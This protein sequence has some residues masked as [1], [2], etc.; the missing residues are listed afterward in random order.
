MKT[1]VLFVT[2][3]LISFT[4]FGCTTQTPDSN[5]STNI[6]SN[7]NLQVPSN[8]CDS[9]DT[10]NSRDECWMDIVRTTLDDSLCNKITNMKDDCYDVLAFGKD[11]YQ[12]CGMMKSEDH[13]SLCYFAF[14]ESENNYS[15]CANATVE[16]IRDECYYEGAINNENKSYCANITTPLTK[17]NCDALTL[18]ILTQQLLNV[19]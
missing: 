19:K 18:T 14:A 11:D 9:I 13:K 6:N 1:I 15:L 3:I 2:F 16:N 17:N 4:L 5:L 8:D 10:T 12:Y 7:T